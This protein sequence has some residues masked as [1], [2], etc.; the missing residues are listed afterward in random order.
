MVAPPFP[1][2]ILSRA[3]FVLGGL[4]DVVAPAADPFATPFDFRGAGA[5]AQSALMGLSFLRQGLSPSMG[6]VSSASIAS[7]VTLR[8][9]FSRRVIVTRCNPKASA[10]ASCEPLRRR[11]ALYSVAVSVIMRRRL[12]E[13]A[14]RVGERWRV[15]GS[16]SLGGSE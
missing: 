13:G 8:F 7:R 4:L 9:P 16:P 14:G 15:C 5:V 1:L 6:R 3:A 10:I 2:V 12:R 11:W